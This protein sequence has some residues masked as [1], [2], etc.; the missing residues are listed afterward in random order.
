MANDN[1]NGTRNLNI[2]DLCCGIGMATL[3]FQAVGFDSLEGVDN[4]AERAEAFSDNTGREGVLTEQDIY[5]EAWQAE[6]YCKVDVVVTGPPC[7]DDSPLARL[8]EDQGRGVV[9]APALAAAASYEPTFIVMEMCGGKWVEWCKEMGATQ[10]E[11][12]VDSALGGATDRKRTFAIW[13]PCQLDIRPVGPAQSWDEVL[14]IEDKGAVLGTETNSKA[15]R[16]KYARAV[17]RPANTVTGGGS[18]FQIKLSDGSIVKTTLEEKAALQGFPGL[19]LDAIVGAERDRKGKREGPWRAKNIA[20]GNGWTKTFG[21]AIGRAVQEA[22]EGV[23]PDE[24][25]PVQ[26]SS[27]HSYCPTCGAALESGD[28]TCHYCMIELEQTVPERT[29]PVIDWEQV[30]EGA[31]E[32]KNVEETT[33]DDDRA[34]WVTGCR[35]DYNDDPTTCYVIM[36]RAPGD[37]ERGD[38]LSRRPTEG[39]PGEQIAKLNSLKRTSL[40]DLR[41]VVLNH[42]ADGEKRTMNR[43]GVELWNKTADI[44]CS[45]TS[46]GKS[47]SSNVE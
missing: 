44:L 13:G 21:M 31:E 11:T 41:N 10:I 7:Q 47:Q 43:I 4:S 28:S 35:P 12:L 8:H 32:A 34:E 26:F 5:V 37:P 19:K 38:R 3:G 25:H 22:L 15:K 40:A 27:R 45:G 2:V 17:G 46:N 6:P 14:G 1:D 18:N 24:C 36:I 33:E 9:K 29:D 23:N 39:G 30:R 42:M 20:I 16:W